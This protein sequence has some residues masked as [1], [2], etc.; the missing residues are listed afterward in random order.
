MGISI[1]SIKLDEENNTLT[2][3][4]IRRKR[5]ADHPLDAGFHYQS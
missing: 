4:P 5:H 1:G 3:V 2:I